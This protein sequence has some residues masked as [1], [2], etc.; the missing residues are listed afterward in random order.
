MRLEP[1]YRIRFIYPDSWEVQMSGT[2][3]TEEQHSM[4]NIMALAARIRLASANG[5]S[6]ELT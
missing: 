5:W 1:L 6:P 2:L 3:G 4:W